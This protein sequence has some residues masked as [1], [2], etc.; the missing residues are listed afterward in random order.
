MAAENRFHLE[1]MP[2]PMRRVFEALAPLL[3]AEGFYLAGGTAVALYYGHRR[4][5]DLDWFRETPFEPMALNA[6]LAARGVALTVS[7]VAE[8]TLI[9]QVGRTKVSLFGYPY[10]LVAPLIVW[11]PYATRLASREDLICMKLAA[12]Q[13]RGLKRDFIDL[14][15]LL[16]DIPLERAV[17]LYTEKYGA[18]AGG[19][20]VYALTYFADADAEPT[21]RLRVP[22]SWRTVKA[23]LT[24]QARRV[25]GQ[26]SILPLGGSD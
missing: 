25:F 20:L 21:P 8:G 6:H 24:E 14:Y 5:V 22:L 17:A 4:S 18:V 2:A 3:S 9:G 13:Q 10:P 11:E 12:I 15:C 1:V 26:S 7:T 19:S 23:F 16:Q